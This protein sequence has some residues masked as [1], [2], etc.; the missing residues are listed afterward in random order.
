MLF[1]TGINLIILEIPEDDATN[2]IDLV[3]PTNHYS[4]N[5]YDTRKRSLI[6][7][8]R[9]NYFEPIYG[10]FNDGKRIHITKTFSE[11]DKKLPKTL[12]AVFSK[13][14]KPT[15]GEKCRT[16][17][18]KPQEYRFSRPLILDKLIEELVNKGYSVTI[19]VLNFQGK[20]IGVLARNRQ[21][22]E[23]FIPCYPSSLT[24]LKKNKKGC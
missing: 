8:K 20:V 5:T 3:C 16:F 12:R 10:Y 21:G 24:S 14:I 7:I 22:A 13:I 17:S 15:L 4:A 9:E 19:Q 18:S 1:E 11:Y 6:L 23:G 2:N